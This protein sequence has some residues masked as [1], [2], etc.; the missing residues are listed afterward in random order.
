M[1]KQLLSIPILIGIALFAGGG[2]LAVKPAQPS[3]EIAEREPSSSPNDKEKNKDED[4]DKGV[5]A[6]GGQGA[7][8]WCEG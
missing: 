1:N 5:T 6:K 7:K 8:L 3:L 2:I 4:G